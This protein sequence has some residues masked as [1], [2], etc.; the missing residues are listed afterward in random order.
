MHK[1]RQ[2]EKGYFKMG[3]NKGTSWS[4][5]WD[6]HTVKETGPLCILTAAKYR[7]FLFV[8]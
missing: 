1:T 7:Q 6:I 3:N 8:L 4:F 5:S 2:N